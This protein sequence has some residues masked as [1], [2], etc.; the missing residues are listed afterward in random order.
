MTAIESRK[1]LRQAEFFSQNNLSKK[2]KKL[3]RG[4]R[5]KVRMTV[6][7]SQG[8]EAIIQSE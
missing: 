2:V 6:G 4:N 7:F 8:P 3:Y 1:S 5:K